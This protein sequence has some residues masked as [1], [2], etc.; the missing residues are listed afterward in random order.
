LFIKEH[1]T[2]RIFFVDE[3]QY[4]SSLFTPLLLQ[5]ETL[6]KESKNFYYI[7]H[8]IKSRNNITEFQF[9]CLSQGTLI[10]RGALKMMKNHG[11]HSFISVAGPSMVS[12]IYL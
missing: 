7:V 4:L 1:P 8:K 10:C 6:I 2:T 3:H 9:V 5:T 12:S 11:C